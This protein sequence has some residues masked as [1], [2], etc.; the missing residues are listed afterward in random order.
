MSEE[1][2]SVLALPVARDGTRLR[3]GKKLHG[4]IL[5]V[6]R[7]SERDQNLQST[8]SLFIYLLYH[9]RMQP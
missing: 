6:E 8:G 5:K 7:W 3:K 2:A 1:V 4:S 9:L